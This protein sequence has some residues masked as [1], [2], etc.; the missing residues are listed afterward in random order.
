[1]QR[2]GGTVV[3]RLV[4]ADAGLKTPRQHLVRINAQNADTRQMIADLKTLN[5]GRSGN[6]SSPATRAW[7]WSGSPVARPRQDVRSGSIS[8]SPRLATATRT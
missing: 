2:S 7:R 4:P 5:P 6:L 1:M 8:F 3:R